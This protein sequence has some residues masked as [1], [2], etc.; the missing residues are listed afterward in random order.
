MPKGGNMK[1]KL[2]PL[3]ALILVLAAPPVALA[4]AGAQAGPAAGPPA[5]DWQGLRG[6]KHGT[7]ILVEFK[8]GDP[9][10]GK[11]MGVTGGTL[12]LSADG[13]TYTLQQHEI[14]RV[15]RLKGRWSRGKAAGV[16]AVI[17]MVAGTFVGAGVM[18]RNEREPGHVP[19]A[20]DT[21][22]LAA[23]ASLGTLAG[24]GVGALLGGRRRGRL[25]YEEK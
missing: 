14:R 10:E 15:Y 13:A 9:L 17:G 21:G 6:L 3:L 16:G 12:N 19:S 1:S 25:L 2:P 22:P 20:D 24:A 5:Q 4:R 8:A 23:G 18:I 7:R 11:F